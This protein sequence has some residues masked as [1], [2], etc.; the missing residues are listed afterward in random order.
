MPLLGQL[1][2]LHTFLLSLTPSDLR[3]ETAE[4][5]HEAGCRFVCEMSSCLQIGLSVLFGLATIATTLNANGV[6]LLQP[7]QLDLSPSTVLS[8][9][10]GTLIFLALLGAAPPFAMLQMPSQATKNT[11]CLASSLCAPFTACSSMSDFALV[12]KYVKF[13]MQECM[14][15]GMLWQQSRG[16]CSWGAPSLCLQGL[17]SLVGCS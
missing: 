9:L 11:Q 10:P 1:L 5:P 13:C 3:K 8:A 7:D 17:A 12:L 6:L 15:S 2:G 16:V 14:R 4:S